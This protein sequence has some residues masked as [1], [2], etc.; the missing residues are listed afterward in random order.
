MQSGK[1]MT[2]RTGREDMVELEETESGRGKSSGINHAPSVYPHDLGKP[3]KK[4]TEIRVLGRLLS[5]LD[6]ARKL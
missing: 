6:Q 1:D 4:R 2:C 3:G 5:I